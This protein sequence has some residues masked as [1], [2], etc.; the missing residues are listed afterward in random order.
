MTGDCYLMSYKGIT[1]A[2]FAW[3]ASD[4]VK[5]LLEP[6]ADIRERLRVTGSPR[7]LVG[8][9]IVDKNFRTERGQL[10]DNRFRWSLDRK[11]D[12]SKRF[13]REHSRYLH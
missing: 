12:R 8:K 10:L 7:E 11:D 6:F 3:A 1:Y 4:T 5:E 13:H 9:E 2:M